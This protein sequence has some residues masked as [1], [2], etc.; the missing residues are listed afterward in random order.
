MFIKV[1]ARETELIKYIQGY[2]VREPFLNAG[3][4]LKIENLPIV[5]RIMIKKKIY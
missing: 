4:E 5:Q 3:L 2:L 1:D